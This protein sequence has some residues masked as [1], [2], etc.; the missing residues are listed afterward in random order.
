MLVT[1]QVQ[2]GAWI[3]PGSK[4]RVVRGGQKQVEESL[5]NELVRRFPGKYKI[6]KPKKS[7]VNHGTDIHSQTGEPK[8][9]LGEGGDLDLDGQRGDAHEALESRR[10]DDHAGD[11]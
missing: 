5:A 8:D 1:I 7:K 10:T 3:P 9:V 11:E 4:K 6:L 2:Y